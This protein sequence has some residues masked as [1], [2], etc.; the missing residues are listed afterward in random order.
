MN[1]QDE[2]HI[3]PF[4]T[5]FSGGF[6]E[7]AR[8]EEEADT[9]CMTGDE[10]QYMPPQEEL[11]I[12]DEAENIDP[13][14]IEQM[15]TPV[16]SDTKDTNPKDNAG[17]L[18]PSYSS[19]PV[20]VLYEIGAALT[21]GKLKY[22]GYN[23]RVAGVRTSVYIDA[24]R[25]HLDAFWEGEDQDPDSGLSH[26]TKAIAGLVVLRDAMLQG[27]IKNDDRPPVTE[28]NFMAD[29]LDRMAELVERYPNP[30]PSFTEKQVAHMRNTPVS[31][32]GG[33]TLGYDVEV[34][35][36]AE[37]SPDG[38]VWA[39]QG[40]RRTD[41]DQ[42]LAVAQ[43]LRDDGYGQRVVRVM[44]AMQKVEQMKDSTEYIVGEMREP[45]TTIF[46]GDLSLTEMTEEEAIEANLE[47]AQRALELEDGESPEDLI[48]DATIDTD[49]IGEGNH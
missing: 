18:K 9:T 22:G 10:R 1:Q 23:W 2:G 12:M 35:I 31:T 17:S 28:A 21:E 11:I 44:R 37:G 30:V 6:S 43:A 16:V 19:V 34:M 38:F 33:Q 26:I 3:D 5:P 27:T 47:A 40:D 48:S 25:R 7:F 36:P 8:Q 29:G 13:E 15:Q 20:P 46:P 39:Q 49:P 14:V 45:L 42:A 4:E 32:Y 24:A 41:P